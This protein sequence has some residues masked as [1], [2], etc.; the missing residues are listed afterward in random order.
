MMMFDLFS[1]IFPLMFLLILGVFVFFLVS[2]LRQWSKN[3]QSPRLSVEATVVSKRTNVSHHHQAGNTAMCSTHTSYYV[4]FQV[5][6]GDRM[7]LLVPG[8]EY[9]LLAEGDNGTLSF[10]GTRFLGFART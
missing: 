9:G 4:T 3:N 7:E 10:Q 2:G 1:V 6:S 8:T 5:A